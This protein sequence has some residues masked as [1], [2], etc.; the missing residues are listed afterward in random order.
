MKLSWLQTFVL[1]AEKRSF[2]IAARELDLTQPAV[3]KH[4]AMLEAY[5]E[6]KLIDRDQ[7]Q[8]VLTE[9]GEILLPYARSV[10]QTLNE[11]EKAVKT[12][13]EQIKGAFDIGASTIPGHY[14]LPQLIRRFREKYPQVRINL[15]I[16]DTEKVQQQVLEQKFCLGAVGA[17][18][19]F[20]TLEAVP[21]ATDEIVL[22]LPVAHPLAN[23]EAIAPET[24]LELDW[25][26]REKGS[27]TRQTVEEHLR[28]W[29]IS[30]EKLHVVA[31]FNTTEAVL[32]A[33]EAGLGGAFV[34]RGAAESRCQQGKLA[35]V[36]LEGRA[37]HRELYLIYS[38][39]RTLPHLARL[40]LQFATQDKFNSYA[41]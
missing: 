36:R 24:L 14:V 41:G 32:A 1:V 17:P 33:V 37:L 22:V 39:Y 6:T 13:A 5:L 38:R 15:Q 9:A 40:F 23:R 8:L 7:R 16:A 10:I 21:F 2:S 34:S 30:P 31:E 11:A 19:E 29:G 3:S 12:H 27:G 18:P 35:C 20:P 4:I 28:R 25:V 26:R